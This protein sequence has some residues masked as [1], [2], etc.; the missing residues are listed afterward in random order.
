[1]AGVSVKI[2]GNSSE[3]LAAMD[4]LARRAETI[5][6]RIRN[7][8]QQR[9]GQR[10]FDGLA[11]A[12]AQI[13]GAIQRAITAAS[14]LNEVIS[15]TG[16]VFTTSS[17]EM[18]SWAENSA[19]AFGLSTS[20]ALAS[21]SSM[22]N[23]FRAMGIAPD[24]AAEMSR[25][26]VELAADLA[27]FN[28]TSVEDATTA[29][30]AALRGEAE[31]IARFG[32]LMNEATLKA[33]ALAKGLSDG[34]SAL[35]PTTKALAAYSLIL[36]KTTTAQGDFARTGSELANSTRTI[37]AQ[38]AD[39]S[40]AFG[41]AFLP[42]LKQIATEIKTID[43]QD[44]ATSTAAAVQSI[45]GAIQTL[46][47]AIKAIGIVYAGLR[48]SAFIT[49]LYSKAAAWAA[50]TA[51]VQANTAA[52]RQN[53]A[54]G[55]AGSLGGMP[56]KGMARGAAGMI[57]Q[58]LKTAGPLIAV[59]AA[60]YGID[61]YVQSLTTANDAMV[62]AFDRANAAVEKF[63]V[64]TIKGKVTSRAEID[65]T[66]TAI[67]EEIA[68]LT[69]ARDA[70]LDQTDSASVRTRII[71]DH[72]ATVRI[73]QAKANQIKGV[74]DAQLEANAATRAA[75]DA[76]AKHAA[77]IKDA[78]ARYAE[79]RK[80]F[81]E[82]TKGINTDTDTAGGAA[83]QLEAI[84]AKEAELRAMLSQNKELPAQQLIDAQE[85]RDDSPAKTRDMEI[86]LA[87]LDLEKKR[88]QASAALDA[89]RGEAIATY[90]QE[91]ALLQAQLSGDA[92]K[93]ANLER[94]AEIKREIARLM[95][96][97]MDAMEAGEF[98]RDMVD[99][100]NAAADTAKEKEKIEKR[101]EA[102]RSAQSTLLDAQALVS[103]N[104]DERNVQK[105]AEE[106]SAQSGIG[107]DEASRMAENESLLE[108][109]TSARQQ[110]D[111]L[112]SKSSIGAVSNTQRL[113]MG[114]GAVSSGIDIARQQ[115]EL[116]RKMV[117]Y[118]AAMQANM[119][120]KPIPDN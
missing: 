97:G 9:I 30:G 11:G 49:Q 94:E 104:T 31:P 19:E 107:M 2:G 106:I 63:N 45:I 76:E 59:A 37:Q 27:S 79:L 58:G 47:P 57:G 40:A 56:G 1:M 78:A 13:P 118:L 29:I 112:G 18:L 119:P 113:G 35:D 71:Q 36:S 70:Q 39:A 68:A 15:K 110:L 41:S 99:A 38:M 86:A 101:S 67:E 33:E 66:V 24:K 43:M 100:R 22:G 8:F 17:A 10:I 53:A 81:D 61:K 117:D 4:T 103:G 111:A 6:D 51:A 21:A 12:A 3:A 75:A 52:L 114:G 26:M 23:L 54:A 42:V 91:M 5:A 7:G 82:K 87:L 84:Q 50:D 48:L 89:A 73:L 34:K 69:D 20:A 92:A 109:M 60:S 120:D 115:V 116:Q 88:T 32:V 90:E 28:N 62:S 25:S 72:A 16:V 65:K 44:M 85:G 95:E 46:L 77:A 102:R 14:D 108:K 80:K 98:A 64:A 93:L 55:A 74:T 83:Q 96:S 105:R